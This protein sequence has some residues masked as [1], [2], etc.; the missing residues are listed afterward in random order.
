MHSRLLRSFLVV[1]EQGNISRAAE[2]LHVSQP[3][4]T[5]SIRQLEQE[6]EVELFARTPKGVQLTKFGDILLQ[7][8][9]VMDNEHQ[10]AVSRINELRLGRAGALRIGA[11]PVWLVNLLPPIIAEYQA[12]NPTVSISLIGGVIDTLVPELVNGDLDLICVSLD[13]PNRSEI[14]KRPLMDTYHVLI[15]DPSHP[16]ANVAEVNAQ[17][18]HSYPWMV[19]KSDYVGSHRIS[20]FFN[21]NGLQPPK[22]A[23][24]T[25]SIHSLLQGL[26]GRDAIAHIPVQMLALAH[27]IGLQQISLRQPIWET[28]AGYAYRTAAHISEPL[29]LFM[30]MLDASTTKD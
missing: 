18:I 17:D 27:E 12:E 16:L 10:H 25:T 4:L 29:K 1:A 19:L 22:I 23:F 14:V 28:K 3:A 5:K 30:N 11:G 7:H 8:V 21:A 9:K 6:Y 15:A 20:S 24:E 26:R 13:F 2:I